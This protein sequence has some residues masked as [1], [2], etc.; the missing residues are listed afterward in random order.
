[1]GTLV[2]LVVRPGVAAPGDLDPTLN[3]TGT[4]TTAVGPADDMSYS[5]AVQ[6]DGKILMTGYASR[7]A[8][9]G[10][11]YDVALVRYNAD[12]SLDTNFNGT[13][14]VITTMGIGRSMGNGVA[15]QADGK[16]LIGG[17]AFDGTNHFAVARYHTNGVMDTTFGTNGNGKVITHVGTVE[18]YGQCVAVQSDGKIVVAGFAK[19]VADYDFGAVRYLTNGVLDTSFSTDG[20][21]T[22]AFS[23]D[24]RA[25]SVALQT[26]GKIVVAGY[27]GSGGYDF[28]VARYTTGGNPDSAFGSGTGKVS[29]PIRTGADY[30]KAVAVQSDGKILVAGTTYTGTNDDIAVVRYAT[31]G[32]LDTTFGTGGKVVTPVGTGDDSGESIALQSDGKILVAGSCAVGTT[33]YFALVRYATNGVLDTTFGTGGKVTTPFGTRHG[34]GAS[35][36]VQADGKILVG[37]AC[38]DFTSGDFALARYDSGD[39]EIAVEQPAGTNLVDGAASVGFGTVLTGATSSREFTIKNTGFGSTLTG[40]GITF[41]GTNAGDFSVSASPAMA[42]GGPDGST[43]FTV[44][45]APTTAGSNSAA[46]HIASNDGDENPFDINLT[47]RGIAPD[48]D[49]DGDGVTNE[50]EVNMASLGFDPLV[51]SSSLRDL[52]HDNALGM[53]L[54]RASDMR[55]LAL[56]YP[57][58]EKD[59][60]T[61]HFHLTIGIEASQSL[62]TWLSLTGFSPTYDE[63][64]GL[65]DIDITP[66]GSSRRFFRVIGKEP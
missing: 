16:I 42:V 26:D 15:V 4:V 21:V 65:I 11:I 27:A 59:P 61:G 66:D 37:G 17:E 31:A 57:L 41:D 18:D 10:A 29:T 40:M 32:A 43:T 20:K 3:G 22:T 54:Y 49:E 53:D 23:G 25:N 8:D 6:P 24:D 28:A 52:I 46:L 34:M 7:S 19:N 47:G 50:A 35:V 51:D 14:K 38:T 60:G 45:F 58:L 63:P 39:P 5:L 9:V 13:G 12:G 55:A 36:A 2:F 56:G 33:F 64:A 30:G 48:A 1:M 62:G 44:R